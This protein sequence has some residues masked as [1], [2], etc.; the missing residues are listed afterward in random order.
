[1][2]TGLLNINKPIGITSMDVVREIKKSTGIKK[3]GHGG[4]LDPMASGVIPIAIGTSTRL[5]EYI[6][7][8]DKSYIATIELGRR[9][10]TY[11]SEGKTVE[12]SDP[13]GI[14]IDEII[15]VLSKFNGEMTQIPPMHSALKV[16]GK[17][18]YELARS[19][20]VIERPPRNVT[21]YEVSLEEFNSPNI[22][23]G[24]RCSKGFYVR[25]FADDIGHLLGCG[26]FL[27]S[28]KRVAS[29]PFKIE[30]AMTLDQ[31]ISMIS[32]GN[33]QELILDPGSC[34]NGAQRIQLNEETE[35]MV[36]HGRAIGYINESFPITDSS[37]AVA[38]DNQSR[39]VAVLRF[40]ENLQEWH[41]E[42][43]FNTDISHNN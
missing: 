33:L 34:I 3:V 9:T 10:D 43:V 42:K 35:T 24:I 6:L 26:A 36:K 22:V 31:T 16:Q 18:L 1:M 40:N 39:F 21:I 29:G 25:T 11:D 8:G 30:D 28:L 7:N 32:D 5:L 12:K 15:N 17:R 13:Q 23:V 14:S 37:L 4:T 41:P 38:Y 27:S 20:T 2:I 19:G